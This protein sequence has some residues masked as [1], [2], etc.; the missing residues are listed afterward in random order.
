MRYI[1]SWAASLPDFS[2]ATLDVTAA[3]LNA[4]LPAGRIVVLCPLAILYKLKLLPQGHVWLVHKAI[5]GLREGASL[6][7]EERTDALTNLTF[8][9]GGGSHTL[10]YSPRFTSHFA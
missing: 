7:S 8:A 3:F 4:P 2:L 9:S 10:S 6:W 5:Y 1:I